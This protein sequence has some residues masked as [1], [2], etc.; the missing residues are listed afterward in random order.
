MVGPLGPTSKAMA[1]SGMEKGANSGLA[2]IA[3]LLLAASQLVLAAHQFSHDELEAEHC[4]VC[5]QLEQV[6]TPLLPSAAVVGAPTTEAQAGFATHRV[7]TVS[8]IFSYASRAPP[9]SS[10]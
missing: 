8:S 9:L 10:R 6:D 5:L 3:V 1:I 4:V 7:F 2:F